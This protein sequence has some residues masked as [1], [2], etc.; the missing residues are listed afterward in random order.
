MMMRKQHGLFTTLLQSGVVLLLTIGSSIALADDDHSRARELMESGEIMPLEQVLK[1]V[2]TDRTWRL[3]E[4]E[5]E[6]EGGV[7][8]YE[9]EMVDEEG[10]VHELKVDARNAELLGK[11]DDDHSEQVKEK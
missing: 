7:W 1:S 10:R 3:L 8:I 6:K 11:D 9:F 2:N 5:L 4:A